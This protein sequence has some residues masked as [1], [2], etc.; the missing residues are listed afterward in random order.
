MNI[1]VVSVVFGLI[2][3]AVSSSPA[4]AALIQGP[5]FISAST[6]IPTCD[7]SICTGVG[8][9]INEIA[10]GDTSNL[11]GYA[12]ADGIVG[13]ITLDLIGNYN[14]DS[15]S[16]WNDI[17]VNQEGVES[18]ML[19][20]YDPFDNL[21]DSTSTLFAPVGQFAAQTYEFSST[22]LNVSKVDLETLTLLGGGVGSRI[23]IREV[24]FN[25]T[26]VPV[27]AAAWLFASGLAAF[28]LV[29]RRRA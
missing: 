25:G 24:A 8:T 27:P 2:M 18:F 12:G 28:G 15:F 23:E 5:A 29:A 7:I 6:D 9:D 10:D 20:F 11:N 26:L 21:I 13:I 4:F 14:L 22:V 17:N 19:H 3:T 1:K 16:L